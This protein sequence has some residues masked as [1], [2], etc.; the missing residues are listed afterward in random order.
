MFNGDFKDLGRFIVKVLKNF[1]G[2]L[3]SN[4]LKNILFWIFILL[5]TIISVIIS[6][7]TYTT[8]LKLVLTMVS[9]LLLQ[10]FWAINIIDTI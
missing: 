6:V 10:L 8:D 1:P 7:M 3:F 4:V 5:P 2:K 9:G